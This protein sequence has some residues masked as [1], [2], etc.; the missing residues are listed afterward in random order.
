MGERM[1]RK[2]TIRGANLADAEAKFRNLRAQFQQQHSWEFKDSPFVVDPEPSHPATNSHAPRLPRN[3]PGTM[4]VCV[5]LP[6][7]TSPDI[8]M[9]LDAAIAIT[10]KTE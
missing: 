3:G 10:E 8:V 5:T 7:D 6:G 1:R 9:A 4:S 2:V